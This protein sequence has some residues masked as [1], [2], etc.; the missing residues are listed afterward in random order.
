MIN[1]SQKILTQIEQL[2]RESPSVSGFDQLDWSPDH[3]SESLNAL[4]KVIS[5]LHFC[6]SPHSRLILKDIRGLLFREQLELDG[7]QIK[8]INDLVFRVRV[9]D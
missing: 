8:K 1:I 6:V 9:G 2:V 7:G 3:Y 5:D 4:C